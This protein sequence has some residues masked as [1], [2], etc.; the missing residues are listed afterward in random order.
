MYFEDSIQFGMYNFIR[1]ERECE[2]R[3]A[4]ENVQTIVLL[5][6]R[7]FHMSANHLIPNRYLHEEKKHA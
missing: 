5:R 4:K 7:H 1:E 2:R 3:K 6:L